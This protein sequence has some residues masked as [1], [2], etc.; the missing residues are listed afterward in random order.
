MSFYRKLLVA[1]VVTMGHGVVVPMVMAGAARADNACLD[2]WLNR[3]STTPTY[4]LG[5]DNCVW[6][7]WTPVWSGGANDTE[8]GMQPGQ[9][10]GAG[11]D[12]TVTSPV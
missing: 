7:P 10:N 9:V 5:P 8:P 4:V 12:A 6:T 11:F 1:A 3:Q 2:V